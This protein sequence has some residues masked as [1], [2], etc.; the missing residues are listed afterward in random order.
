[1]KEEEEILLLKKMWKFPEIIENVVKTY[2]VHLLC[3]YLLDLAK[4]FHSYYQKHRVVGEDKKLTE[5]RLFLIKGL[6]IVF[7]LSL[8]LLNITLPERM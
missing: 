5:T 1:M 3:E 8:N 2:G 7:S 6:Y 4:T